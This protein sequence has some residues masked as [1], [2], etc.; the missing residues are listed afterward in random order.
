L[1]EPVYTRV[2]RQELEGI[3]SEVRDQRAMIR[4]Q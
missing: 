1:I 3:G 4:Q 2:V